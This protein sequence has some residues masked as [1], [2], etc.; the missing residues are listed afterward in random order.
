MTPLVHSRP[1]RER[2]A[3]LPPSR[4]RHSVGA[5]HTSA[6]QCLAANVKRCPCAT[7]TGKNTHL[8][9]IELSTAADRI[10]HVATTIYRGE[11]INFRENKR[12]VLPPL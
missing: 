10:T 3:D 7:G 5:V 4:T 8:L 2:A 1:N 12:S 11:T 6:A 9:N